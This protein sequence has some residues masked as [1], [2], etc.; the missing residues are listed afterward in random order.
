MRWAFTVKWDSIPIALSKF[1]GFRAKSKY[2]SSAKRKIQDL[3]RYGFAH[4]S[5]F[6][7]IAHPCLHAIIIP[8]AAFSR[9]RGHMRKPLNLQPWWGST[10]ATLATPSILSIYLD[11]GSSLNLTSECGLVLRWSSFRVRVMY[12]GGRFALW[13]YGNS[14]TIRITAPSIDRWSILAALFWRTL[15]FLCEFLFF[16]A[17]N[18]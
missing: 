7:A 1:G 12:V 15:T 14:P 4:A 16:P 8:R 9:R 11:S 10:N 13:R 2:L 18:Y 5:Y 17:I 3:A 6:P